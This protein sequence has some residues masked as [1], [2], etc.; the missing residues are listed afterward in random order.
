M[1]TTV[2]EHYDAVCDSSSL[3]ADMWPLGP[4]QVAQTG[5]TVHTLYAA[6][7]GTKTAGKRAARQVLKQ[8]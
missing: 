6:T 8:D 7:P 4:Q 3:I 2:C 1:T 5:I